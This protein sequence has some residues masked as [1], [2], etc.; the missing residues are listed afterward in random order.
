[1]DFKNVKTGRSGC[2]LVE[3][4]EKSEGSNLY[5]E[6]AFNMEY[7]QSTVSRLDNIPIIVPRG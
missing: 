7:R 5:G 1:M 3:K 2:I 6:L 4:F